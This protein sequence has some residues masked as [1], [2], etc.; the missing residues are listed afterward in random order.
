ML[1]IS[2]AS[3]I[4]PSD[5]SVSEILD[6]IPPSKKQKISHEVEPSLFLS[7]DTSED[8]AIPSSKQPRITVHPVNLKDSL[9]ES[10]TIEVCFSSHEKTYKKPSVCHPQ[11]NKTQ[12]TNVSSLNVQSDEVII[13]NDSTQQ[14]LQQVAITQLSTSRIHRD[15]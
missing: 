10:G 8:L 2:D 1:F 11:Q 13:V 9:H 7:D 3:K 14:Q 15:H 12:I 6:S 5:D 4:R